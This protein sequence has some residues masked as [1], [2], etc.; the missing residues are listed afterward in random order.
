M[1][2]AVGTRGMVKR[3]EGNA[4]DLNNLPEE[5]GKQPVEESS[6]TTAASADTSQRETETLNRARQLVFSNEGLAGATAMGNSLRDLH[7]GS[8]HIPSGGFQHRGVDPCLSFRPVYPRGPTQ[9]SNPSQMQPY[10]YPPSSS[11]SL[12]YS[13]PSY[14]PSHLP[15]ASSNYYPAHHPNYGAL[16]HSFAMEGR[17]GGP[18]SQE[19]NWGCSYGHVQHMDSSS[20]VDRFRDNFHS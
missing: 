9:P 18:R 20:A 17:D 16:A 11:H 3:S 14:Q 1:N 10:V 15:A 8:S 7:L 6:M 4:L 2:P 19:E 12:P 5:H 13:P